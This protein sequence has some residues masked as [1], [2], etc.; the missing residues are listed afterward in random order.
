MKKRVLIADADEQFC[1]ELVAALEGN[2][3]FEVM[4][5]ATDGEEAIKMLQTNRADILVMD[6]L[7]PK[8]DGLTV[9]ENVRSMWKRPKV[10]ITSVFIS[11]YVADSA[12]R[13]GAQQ[14]LHKPCSVDVMIGNLERMA[15]GEKG[16]PVIFLWNSQQNAA[17][18]VTSI[19]HE[20]GVPAHIKGYQYVRE[21]IILAANDEDESNA[22]LKCRYD[23]V[24]NA[25]NTTAKKV[26]TAIRHAI[27]VAWDR[28]DLD[29]L[30]GYFGYTVSNTK[31]KPTNSEFI[32]IVADRIRLWW[33]E[34]A[35]QIE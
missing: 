12:V 30:Q 17:S 28:G 13:L 22:L 20:I 14:L 7:L 24:A 1:N 6:L 9:L 8:I 33:K 31:G 21:A 26:E 15:K 5:V 18:L 19:L 32:S 25:F 11:K 16:G 34:N 10:L 2:E 29:T 4:G 27:E 3:E 35:A 23:E